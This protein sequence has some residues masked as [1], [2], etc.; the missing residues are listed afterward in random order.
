MRPFTPIGRAAALAVLPLFV[1]HVGLWLVHGAR[2]GG[3]LVDAFPTALGRADA[4]VFVLAYAAMAVALWS[5]AGGGGRR[6]RLAGRALAALAGAATGAGGVGFLTTGA[7]L[8]GAM[9]VATIA[10][11]ASALVVGGG[12]WRAG[13][14]RAGAALLLFGATTLPLGF[15]LPA[16]VGTA[17][18]EYAVYEAHFLVAGALWSAAA[19]PAHA[20]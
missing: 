13:E 15:A 11:F 1:L 16:L 2:T 20:R 9:P 3:L 12:L 17:L 10:L 18:P 4:R 7:P 14:R 6:V 8:P 5:A 19:W